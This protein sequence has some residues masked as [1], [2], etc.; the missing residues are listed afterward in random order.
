MIQ[1][2]SGIYGM[3]AVPAK[4]KS[5]FPSDSSC[6]WQRCPLASPVLLKPWASLSPRAA[7]SLSSARQVPHC[8]FSL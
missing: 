5:C 4:G 6:R 7:Q 2:L 8:L 3:F 1:I